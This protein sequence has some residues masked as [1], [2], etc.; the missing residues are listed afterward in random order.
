MNCRCEER[1]ESQGLQFYMSQHLPVVT[2]FGQCDE[3]TDITI[4]AVLRRVDDD[5]CMVPSGPV[6]SPGMTEHLAW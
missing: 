3:K 1:A 2:S 6:S 4:Q 5:P